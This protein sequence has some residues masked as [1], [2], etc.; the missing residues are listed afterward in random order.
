MRGK[1]I[2]FAPRNMLPEQFTTR[3]RA[4]LG[5]E[6][7]A[8]EH[9]L[10][11]EPPP[12]S[13]RVNPLKRPASSENELS[14]PTDNVV[15]WCRTGYYLERRPSF[16]FDPLFHAGAYYVQ[17]ASSM[18]LEYYIK[19]YVSKPVSALDL[20]AAPGGKATHLA[21]LL[22]AGSLL[23][24]NEAIRS[25]AKILLE[26]LIKW[27]YPDTVITNDDPSRIGMRK[28]CFDLI[29]CDLPCSGEGMFR[30]DRKSVSEWSLDNVNLCAQRQRRIVADV[31]PALKKGGILLYSTCT[32]NREENEDNL[33]WICR[34]LGAE[35]LEKPHRFYPHQTKG[36]G[37]FIG[38]MTKISEYSAKMTSKQTKT[39]N[40]ILFDFRKILKNSNKEQTPPHALAMS[41]LSNNYPQWELTLDTA[42]NYLRKQSLTNM[43]ADLSKGYVIV[44]YKNHP[45]GFVKNIGSRANN[46]YPQEWRIRI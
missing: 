45:L 26:N 25:R 19:K 35:M 40:N 6:Y 20:C 9:S 32:Y 4:M 11:E 33:N 31:F 8:F 39:A 36:E 37:F 46:L 24:A 14:A 12:V 27:G 3:M 21:S 7:G 2:N 43:P 41:T 30:R 10:L 29:L 28:N 18:F 5:D 17:E 13:I 15:P 34:E 23:T 22:P 44:T 16:T 38:A 1:N 42:L